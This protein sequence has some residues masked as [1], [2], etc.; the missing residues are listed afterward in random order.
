M[1]KDLERAPNDSLKYRGPLLTGPPLRSRL[2]PSAQL[3]PSTR[4]DGTAHSMRPNPPYPPSFLIYPFFWHQV[5]R[6]SVKRW[7][8]VAGTTLQIVPHPWFHSTHLPSGPPTLVTRR[9][10]FRSFPPGHHLSP[11]PLSGPCHSRLNP[12]CNAPLH[13]PALMVLCTDTL[14]PKCS[15]PLASQRGTTHAGTRLSSRLGARRG[16]KGIPP[17]LLQNEHR[18]P[19]LAT[20]PPRPT[21]RPVCL[22]WP[23]L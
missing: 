16:K 18:P 3:Q 20:L 2:H 13:Y 4:V 21:P 19:L 22:L 6:S 23:S 15:A 14:P 1:C 10:R 5:L 7:V 11:L 8:V 17:P 12:S 9:Q